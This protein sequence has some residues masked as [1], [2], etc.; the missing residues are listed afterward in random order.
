MAPDNLWTYA[1]LQQISATKRML[2][3]N[4]AG[5]GNIEEVTLT[6]FLDWIGSAEQGDILFRGASGW[7]RLGAGTAGQFLRT[8]GAGQNV[9]WGTPGLTLL[10]SGTLS[11]VAA[12]DIVLTTYSAF[13][14]FRLKA[15]NFVPAT[16]NVGLRMRFSSNGGSTFDDGASDYMY[17]N[18]RT[19]VAAATPDGSS[20]ASN[21]AMIGGVGSGAAEGVCADIEI[22]DPFATTKT[23][24]SWH[25]IAYDEGDAARMSVGGGFRNA[26]QDTDAIRVVFETGSIA[27][28]KWALYGYA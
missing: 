14:G 28:G 24:A 7:E 12:L 2:G 11:T 3:R 1:K 23:K 20:G 16:D 9:A 4:T 13:R 18:D 27:S 17:T 15:T 19:R 25:A 22:Y 10:D 21:L 26:S 8:G 5:A 6:Q